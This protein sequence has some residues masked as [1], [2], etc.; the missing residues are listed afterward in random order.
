MLLLKE[1]ARNVPGSNLLIYLL[2]GE[3][4]S[5]K[6]VSLSLACLTINIYNKTL[7][8]IYYRNTSSEF[9]FIDMIV[10]IDMNSLVFLLVLRKLIAFNNGERGDFECER[11]N[12]TEQVCD[13]A[14]EEKKE[15]M[16]KLACTRI[17]AK[18]AAF[19]NYLYISPLK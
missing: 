7:T 14:R 1:N 12:V 4:I 15:E 9:T 10:N 2:C 3:N 17:I 13:W 18:S 11:E 6:S 19:I 16:L 8:C 5:S